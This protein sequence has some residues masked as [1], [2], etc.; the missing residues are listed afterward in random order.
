MEARFNVDLGRLAEMLPFG[1]R[2][3][4]VLA[5]LRAGFAPYTERLAATFRAERAADRFR[6]RHNGQ[7]CYLRAA[8]NERFHS[9]LPGVRFEIGENGIEKPWLYAREETTPADPLTGHTFALAEPE[10]TALEPD[11]QNPNAPR[12]SYPPFEPPYAPSEVRRDE[13]HSFVIY[14]PSDLYYSSL[15]AIQRFV[16]QYRLVTRAPQYEPINS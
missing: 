4:S 8:L 9:A 7:V 16:E 11:P 5:V 10:P 14:V 6:L 3:A 12:V 13:L 1:M 2:S 15:P